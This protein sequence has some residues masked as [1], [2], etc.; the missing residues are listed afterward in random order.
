[1]AQTQNA[2]WVMLF[3]SS[4][5]E[6]IAASGGSIS[7]KTDSQH[8]NFLSISPPAIRGPLCTAT[9]LCNCSSAGSRR[10]AA[11]RSSGGATQPPVLD[12]SFPGRFLRILRSGEY[13]KDTVLHS[14][15]LTPWHSSDV[16]ARTPTKIGHCR[17]LSHSTE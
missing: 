13:N 8:H 1:M 6:S 11:L 5:K 4:F 9:M 12:L 3:S 14:C 7:G 2:G 17:I 10:G 16:P 15:D